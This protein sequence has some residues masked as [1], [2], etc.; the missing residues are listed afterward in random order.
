M[1]NLI[2]TFG[3]G[4]LYVLGLPFFLLALVL[5]GAFGLLAFI[6]QIF[7]SIILFFTGQKFFPELP[8]DKQLR[9]LRE[10]PEP[11][12]KEVQDEGDIPYSPAPNQTEKGTTGFYPYMEEPVPEEEVLARINKEESTIEEACFGKQEEKT[13]DQPVEEFVNQ[14]VEEETIEEEEEPFEEL[15]KDDSNFEP[16]EEVEQDS[17]EEMLE[18]TSEV[19]EEEQDNNLEVYVPK[20]SNYTDD[21]FDDDDTDD[22]NGVD[23]KF[24]I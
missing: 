7:R 8:E 10:G 11:E 20:S 13:I 24:D 4:I 15:V 21:L 12:E 5:F 9:L 23:I 22:N 19:E 6:F 16:E 3:K 2:K 1:V 18:T 14:E 17:K